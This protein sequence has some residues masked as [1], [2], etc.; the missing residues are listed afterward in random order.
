MRP[1]RPVPDEAGCHTFQAPTLRAAPYASQVTSAATGHGN[2]LVSGAWTIEKWQS[3][4]DPG[5]DSETTA[6][7]SDGRTPGT[8]DARHV[9]AN[10]QR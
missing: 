9:D 1:L 8:S 4:L 10:A 7:K 2:V 5:F 6:T 3:F